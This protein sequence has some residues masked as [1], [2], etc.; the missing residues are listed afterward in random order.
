MHVTSFVKGETYFAAM[1]KLVSEGTTSVCGLLFTDEVL[2]KKSVNDVI[3]V[4]YNEFLCL[5]KTG[6]LTPDKY[7]CTYVSTNDFQYAGGKIESVE[8]K[9]IEVIQKIL[10]AF[11]WEAYVL[12]ETYKGVELFYLKVCLPSVL[13]K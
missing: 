2:F 3:S 13:V 10:R 1:K 12:S 5:K 6:E 4:I 11:G 8:R 9:Q 7:G